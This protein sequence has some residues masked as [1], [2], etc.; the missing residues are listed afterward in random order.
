MR[1]AAL[2]AAIDTAWVASPNRLTIPASSER[3]G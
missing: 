3:A 2:Q 1:V